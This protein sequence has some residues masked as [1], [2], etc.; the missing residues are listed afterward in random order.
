LFPHAIEKP[1]FSAVSIMQ[2][3]KAGAMGVLNNP[4]Q[5]ATKG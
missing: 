2:F 5:H 1:I 3:L 4:Q